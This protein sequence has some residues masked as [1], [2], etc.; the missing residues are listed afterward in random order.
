MSSPDEPTVTDASA[1]PSRDD[2]PPRSTSLAGRY[3]ILSLLGGGG[4]GRVYLARDTELDEIVAVKVLQREMLDEPS[5]LALLRKEVKLARRVTHPNVARTFDIDIHE[6]Q[7]FITMEYVEGESLASVLRRGPLPVATFLEI[8][9]SLCD[10]LVAA[11]AAGVVHRDLKPSNLILVKAP[12]GERV[13]LIDFGI[14]R[15]E[16]EETRITNMGAPL[17]TPGYMSPEQESGGQIDARSDLFAVGAI[18]YECL[19]GEPPPPVPS[20][21]WGR[22]QAQDRSARSAWKALPENFRVVIE[23]AMAPA[24]DDRFQ[25][26]RALAQAIRNIEAE[27]R[28]SGASSS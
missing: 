11:H 12:D 28:A 22:N 13:K 2:P 26:A 21:L 1:A 14:A 25:D 20:G 10:G 17:G 7:R 19:V 16:W 6:G 3:A 9:R 24:P 18:L 8:A 23:K 15:V 4:M 27:P 5:A